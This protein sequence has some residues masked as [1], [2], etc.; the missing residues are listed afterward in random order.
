MAR[1]YYSSVAQRTTL[2]IGVDASI[3]TFI[4]AAVAGW[5]S[6]FPYTLIIDEDTVNEE[7]VEVVGRSSTTLTVVRGRDGTSG[8]SHSA[9]AS[10]RHGVS[11]RDF[12]EPNAHEN[13]STTAHGLTIAN[14]VTLAGTQTLTN[15]TISQAQITNLTTDLAA[16]F[17]LNVSTSAQ[18]ASYTLVA[19]DAQKVVEMSVATANT[20]TIPT[21]DSVPF[22][23]GTSIFIWQ[24]GAGQTTIAG[25]AGVTVNSFIGLKIAGQWA[26]ATLIKRGTNTWGVIG[27]LAA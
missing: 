26:G 4:V 20:L 27:A 2:S 13:N 25:A 16:K 23:N 10:V 7:I 15:K 22:P 17:P 11:A 18:T 1:R 19:G 14:V 8:I 12:D 24:T 3:T 6:S 21:N 5:P 9:G